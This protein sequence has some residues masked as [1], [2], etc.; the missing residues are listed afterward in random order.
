MKNKPLSKRPSMGYELKS[1]LY[2]LSDL[3]G[4]KSGYEKPLCVDPVQTA[5]DYNPL[6]QLIGFEQC[7]VD[8]K[9]RRKVFSDKMN[10]NAPIQWGVEVMH[11]GHL[12]FEIAD[13]YTHVRVDFRE[14][15]PHK[16]EQTYQIDNLNI[17]TSGQI[18]YQI[19]C[20]SFDQKQLMS[21]SLDCIFKT[22]QWMEKGY[23]S[24]AEVQFAKISDIID[25]I[26]HFSKRLES[27]CSLLA[28]GIQNR[29]T[30]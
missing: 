25:E 8:I 10:S 21:K 13:K 26:N 18:E 3:F 22:V 28:S 29:N 23:C 24:A 14:N 12:V 27:E 9:K 20:E 30:P 19:D 15:W 7:P 1:F 16:E 2:G 11:A 6:F 5:Y 17:T 4:Y